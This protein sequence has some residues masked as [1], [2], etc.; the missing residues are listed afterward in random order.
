MEHVS[1]HMGHSSATASK[2]YRAAIHG[3][4]SEAAFTTIQLAFMIEKPQRPSTTIQ[5]EKPTIEEFENKFK[6]TPSLSNCRDFVRQTMEESLTS[7]EIQR[8]PTLGGAFWGFGCGPP[9]M[10]WGKKFPTYEEGSTGHLYPC[11][12]AFL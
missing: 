7:L 9:Q 3:E 5:S 10:L 8:L 4:R 12:N 6:G 1:R 11:G 2:Y